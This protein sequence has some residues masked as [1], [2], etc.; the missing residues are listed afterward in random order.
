MSPTFD[1][2]QEFC[3][4]GTFPNGG[5]LY[6]PLSL[7]NNAKVMNASRD[8]VPVESWF[9]IGINRG[10]N[11]GSYFKYV[12]SGITVPFEIN[13]LEGLVS[14]DSSHTCV[15]ASNYNELFWHVDICNY[16]MYLICESV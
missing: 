4:I 9:H 3:K 13:W 2:A 12:S 14:A 8:F 5:H 15:Y 7:E 6:E 10:D 16:S 1:S 11:A